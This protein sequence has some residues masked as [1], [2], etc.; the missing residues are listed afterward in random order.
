MPSPSGFAFFDENWAEKHKMLIFAFMKKYLI[1]FLSALAL[2]AGCKTNN[3][4]QTMNNDK[5]LQ[6][7]V[8]RKNFGPNHA[9]VTTPQPCV[10]I[11]TWDQI[12][13]CSVKVGSPLMSS[14][15]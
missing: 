14:H 7:V 5:P 3:N 13:M 6:E 8:G 10:M 9:L 2:L 1:I 11:A 12:L 4:T 15:R